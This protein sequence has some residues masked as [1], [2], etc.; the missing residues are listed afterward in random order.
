MAKGDLK[1][2][3]DYTHEKGKEAVVMF[4]V[5][6][7]AKQANKVPNPYC[8]TEKSPV[9]HSQYCTKVRDSHKK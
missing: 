6:T 7:K 4:D 5:F 3:A 2:T 9:Y 1:P 8:T